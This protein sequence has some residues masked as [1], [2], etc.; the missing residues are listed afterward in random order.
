[1]HCAGAV[2]ATPGR[3]PR[4]AGHHHDASLQAEGGQDAGVCRGH[5]RRLLATPLHYICHGQGKEEVDVSRHH[6][7]T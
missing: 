1:M 3:L 4:P 6:K 7:K 5:L 2:E